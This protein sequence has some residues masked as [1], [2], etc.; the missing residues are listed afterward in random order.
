MFSILPEGGR[1][2]W[3]FFFFFF[4]FKAL[5]SP[6]GVYYISKRRSSRMRKINGYDIFVS[7]SRNLSALSA[8]W[9]PAGE[10]KVFLLSYDVRI[11]F[12]AF[13][14]SKIFLRLQ[15]WRSARNKNKEES[16]W[17]L[18]FREMYLDIDDVFTFPGSSDCAFNVWQI[19]QWF[20]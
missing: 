12:M 4:F 13:H 18:S 1:E 15:F 11:I 8:R 3:F 17:F 5:R 6:L 7:Q 16:F 14:F 9:K 10:K 2:T 20:Y 19:N